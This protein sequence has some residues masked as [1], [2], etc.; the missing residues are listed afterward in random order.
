MKQKRTV[1]DHCGETLGGFAL[2]VY[3]GIHAD[4][5]KTELDFCG[6]EHAQAYISEFEHIT[7][8][9]GRRYLK[10]PN[11][12]MGDWNVDNGA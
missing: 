4:E 8:A 5:G 12:S 2:E 3:Y 1:C 6:W 11:R 10:R 7:A 9:D